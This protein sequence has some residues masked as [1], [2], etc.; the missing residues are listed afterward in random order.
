MK[1]YA[2]IVTI[3]AVLALSLL[4]YGYY[5]GLKIKKTI[6]DYENK[7][8]TMHD[9]EEAMQQEEQKKLDEI[10]SLA[11]I[12]RESSS[13]FMHPGNFKASS[14][15]PSIVERLK[16]EIE[17]ITD[18]TLKKEIKDKWDAF[19]QS[20]NLNDYRD[21]IGTV[22]DII[23]NSSTTLEPSNQKPKPSKQND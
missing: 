9:E 22:A 14:F 3:I 17:N 16:D 19:Q 20:Q 12:L 6:A 18:T 7:I 15:N 8:Q 5:T 13:S 23:R 21:F 1:I 2:I 11:G 4:G 10:S